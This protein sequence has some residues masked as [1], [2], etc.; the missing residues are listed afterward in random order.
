MPLVV[1]VAALVVVEGV[2]VMEAVETVDVVDVAVGRG[3]AIASSTAGGVTICQSGCGLCSQL[4]LL[5][6]EDE[7]EGGRVRW[8]ARAA[9]GGHVAENG[10]EC[11]WRLAAERDSSERAADGRASRIVHD[12]RPAKIVNWK[13]SHHS[14]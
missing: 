6:A 13:R 5:E 9:S 4:R 7:E 2:D 14:L 11:G 8:K 1:V 12:A 3:P 10:G